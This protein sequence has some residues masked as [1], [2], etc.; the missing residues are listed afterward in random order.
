MIRLRVHRL[1]AQSFTEMIVKE[2]PNKLKFSFDC[3]KNMIFPRIYNFTVCIGGSKS[4]Q[5]HN[6]IQVYTCLGNVRP[7]G[8]NDITSMLNH[9]LKIY[10]FS[11]AINVAEMFCNGCPG[12]NNNSTIID[13]WGFWLQTQAWPTINEVK[14]TFPVV[15]YSYLPPD[16]VFGRIEK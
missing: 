3:Q 15:G 12:Q 16:R 11:D 9:L 6:S 14:L 7:K 4:A 2:L 5:T 10:A 8:S 1:E 13:I